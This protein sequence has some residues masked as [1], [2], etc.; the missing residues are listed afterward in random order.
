MKCCVLASVTMSLTSTMVTVVGRLVTLSKRSLW[1]TCP[2]RDA[3]QDDPK[4]K[5]SYSKKST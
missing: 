1:L 3:G 5:K 2:R 4:H